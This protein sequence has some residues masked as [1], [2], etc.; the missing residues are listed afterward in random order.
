MAVKL[1]VEKDNYVVRYARDRIRSLTRT[2]FRLNVFKRWTYRRDVPYPCSCPS[3][4]T[5]LNRQGV[6]QS[7]HA[8]IEHYACFK[9]ITANELCSK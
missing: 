2:S 6:I 3:Y 9:N 4:L 8:K 7:R 1:I 5:C